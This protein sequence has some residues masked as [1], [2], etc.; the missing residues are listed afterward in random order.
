MNDAHTRQLARFREI[1]P[2]ADPDWVERFVTEA[3]LQDLDGAAIGDALATIE[4]HIRETGEPVADAFGPPIEYAAALAASGASAAPGISRLTVGSVLLGLTGLLVPVAVG[5]WVAE[6]SVEV[7]GGGVAS[8]VALALGGTVILLRT[9]AVLRVFARRRVASFSV[10]LAVLTAMVAAMLVGRR[11]WPDPIVTVPPVTLLIVGL[12]ALVGATWL[13]WIDQTSDRV[14]P[15]GVANPGRARFAWVA[16]LSYVLV[17]VAGTL[18]TV[19]VFL[20]TRANA[21]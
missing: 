7:D 20:V 3:R 6:R 14:R 9:N 18:V 4:S 16:V 12:V 10:W 2:T 15:P 8:A 21:T 5:A 17:A 19:V 11:A 13:S 1:V